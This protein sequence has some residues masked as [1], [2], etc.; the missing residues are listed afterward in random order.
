MHDSLQR[1]S[2]LLKFNLND[3]LIR[4]DGL[5]KLLS[6]I[7]N[8]RALIS[9]SIA[10]SY[11]EDERAFSLSIGTN[12][13]LKKLNIAHCQL[14]NYS[15]T[16]ISDI[17]DHNIIEKLDIS[18]NYI[19]KAGLDE[20]IKA[21]NCNS[22]L[23]TLNISGNNISP[24]GFETLSKILKNTTIKKLRMADCC[25]ESNSAVK[26]AESLKINKGLLVL[27]VSSNRMNGISNTAFMSSLVSNNILSSLTMQKCFIDDKDAINIS[28]MLKGNKAIRMLDL[29]INCIN[30][31][32]TWAIIGGIK[33]NKVI[34]SMLMD[35]IET[36]Y[37]G[38]NDSELKYY[39][40]RNKLAFIR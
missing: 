9:L 19:Q 34:I 35:R 39:L 4:Q 16:R 40:K 2:S 18:L 14:T 31:I 36:G 26:I 30:K 1:S 10:D 17:I 23:K 21:I 38:Y 15:A 22:S 3:N 5:N 11:M 8:N 24:N 13:S 27:D 20:I 12:Q 7:A 29:Q 25:M 37:N 6:N 32:G 33:N 28:A